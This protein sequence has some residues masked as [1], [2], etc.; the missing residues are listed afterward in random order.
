VK[1]FLP[2]SCMLSALAHLLG[3]FPCL[4]T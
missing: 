4:L 1:P 3:A 2:H